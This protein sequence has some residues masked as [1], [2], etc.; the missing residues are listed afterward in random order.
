MLKTGYPNKNVVFVK[1]K[2]E[3][4]IP[5]NIPNKICI[6][7][8]D[9]DWYESTFHELKHLFPLLTKGGVLIVDDYGHWRG[10]RMAVDKYMAENGVVI[11]LNRVDYTGRVGVKLF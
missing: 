11:L 4:T 7:R 3:D 1:G 6:L 10:A 9:T 5:K 8:L 2:V